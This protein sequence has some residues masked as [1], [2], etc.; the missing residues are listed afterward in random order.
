MIGCG[1]KSAPAWITQGHKQLE[2]YKTDFLTG[3]R[4]IVTERYFQ[5]AVEE[6]KKSGDLDLLQKAWLTR[7]ALQVAVLE[8][9]E[10]GDYPKIEAALPVP[11]NR[12]FHLFLTGDPAA[13]DASLLPKAYRP[14]LTALQ[15]GNTIDTAKKIAG[16][17]DPL[18][19]L[20]ASGLTMRLQR[21]NETILQTAAETAAQ[22]G[23]QRAL[24]AWLKELKGFY[25]K[26]EETTKAEAIGR[27]LAVIA[28]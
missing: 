14:F 9:A 13:V 10:E 26:R 28:P 17:D 25:E 11:A 19:R 21:A 16:I 18:S 5:K 2:T 27:R 6:L 24:L 15:S 22:N 23:W 4:P 1:F 7:M 8:K 3:E 20:I 12:N